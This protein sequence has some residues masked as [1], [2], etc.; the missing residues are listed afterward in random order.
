M[1]ICETCTPVTPGSQG[2]ALT[3]KR[4]RGRL[5]HGHTAP[6]ALLCCLRACLASHPGDFALDVFLGTQTGPGLAESQDVEGCR[7]LRTLFGP[8]LLLKQGHP[9]LLSNPSSQVT[10]CWCR[11][12]CDDTSGAWLLP[13]SGEMSHDACRRTG[14]QQLIAPCCCTMGCSRGFTHCQPLC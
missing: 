6:C 8:I 13:A 7:N 4:D 14:R 12:F 9:E 5:D 2:G 1:P 10:E 3:Q 11:C